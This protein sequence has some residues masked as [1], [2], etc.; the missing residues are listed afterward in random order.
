MLKLLWAI[1]VKL[2]VMKEES[3][4]SNDEERALVG[5]LYNNVN[6]GT[7]LEFNGELDDRGL[8]RIGVLRGILYKLLIKYDLLKT[9]S[10]ENMLLLGFCE[11]MDKDVLEKFSQS[12]NQHLKKRAD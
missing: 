1:V 2:L 4:L 8:K 10:S 7:T 6:F 3:A 9:L 11:I 12:K 5:V